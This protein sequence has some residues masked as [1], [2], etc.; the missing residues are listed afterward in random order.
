MAQ[1]VHLQ[2]RRSWDR[3]PACPP[4]LLAFA[5]EQPTT[6]VI[7][8]DGVSILYLYR[9]AGRKTRFYIQTALNSTCSHQGRL[10]HIREP[11]APLNCLNQ[12][13]FLP[14]LVVLPIHRHTFPYG[15][16]QYFGSRS[17]A[18]RSS[19]PTARRPTRSRNI[20]LGTCR[21]RQ[22]RLVIGTGRAPTRIPG[23]F[24]SVPSQERATRPKRT[25]AT[26]TYYSKNKQNC[27]LRQK[28]LTSGRFFNVHH[29]SRW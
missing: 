17:S 8:E 19:I 20:T 16:H 13:G 14:F 21:G 22:G 29:A 9:W 11:G 5:F 12:T 23:T 3:T 28:I 26:Q 6:A 2:I 27:R 10:D 24:P 4:K 18:L 15:S 7:L 1:L 25:S